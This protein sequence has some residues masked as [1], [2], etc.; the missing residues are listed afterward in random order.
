MYNTVE[1][2]I[3]LDLS[4]KKMDI[5]F[6]KSKINLCGIGT[7]K[8][9]KGFDRLIRIHKRLKDDGYPIHTYLLGEGPEE[10]TIRKMIDEYRLNDSITLLGYQIN[11][12]KYIK[13]SD[14]FVCCSYAEGFSTAATEALIVGT[15]VCT[16]DVSGMKE[17]L[18]ENN[19]YG[20][21]TD[22]D[23]E[24]LYIGLKN[25]IDDPKLLQHYKLKALE[26]ARI[27]ETKNTVFSVED[28]LTEVVRRS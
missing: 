19:E 4:K 18:G 12:Y 10:K 1:S 3:I 8:K 7:L 13:N 23:D 16:V 26:R 27:F 20:I 28:K 6:D 24:Q 14:I 9:S 22:N 17:M 25:L 15:A 2:D 5:R 21:V 11:P